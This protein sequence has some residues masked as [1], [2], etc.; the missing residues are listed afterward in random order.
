MAM[1]FKT[2]LQLSGA[3][4][5]VHAYIVNAKVLEQPIS[6]CNHCALVHVGRC[7]YSH[8]T[9]SQT[10]FIHGILIG[11]PPKGCRRRKTKV[12]KRLKVAKGLSTAHNDSH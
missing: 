3:V 9:T 2:T 5:G 12:A 8:Y 6:M 4:H 1:E 10:A 7:R 11:K